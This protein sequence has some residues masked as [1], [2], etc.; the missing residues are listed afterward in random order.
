MQ[1]MYE[2]NVILGRILY[3][4]IRCMSLLGVKEHETD[5]SKIH[6]IVLVMTTPP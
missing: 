2:T 3:E 4:E 1:T 5:T 6:S